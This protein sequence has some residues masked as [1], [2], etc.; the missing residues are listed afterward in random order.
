MKTFVE[1]AEKNGIKLLHSGPC[2][3]C[4]AP[5][6]AGV[7]KCFELFSQ[8]LNL[9]DLSKPEV[10]ITRFLSVDSHALQH[11]EVHGRWNNHLHLTRLHL[12]IERKF[13]WDYKKTPI[14]SDVLKKY[15]KNNSNEYLSP[16]SAG[17]RGLITISDIQNAKNAS[18]LIKIIHEWAIS[19][20]QVYAVYHKIV[21]GI[22]DEFEESVWK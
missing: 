18:E 11:S 14:L 5:V 6:E 12:I 17:Q 7:Y 10:Y 8:A 3:F 13:I 22:A 4:H 15:K 21:A 16:P 1:Q 2:Q 9:L 20:Y 19:V